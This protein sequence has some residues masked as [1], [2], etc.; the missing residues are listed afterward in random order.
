MTYTPRGVAIHDAIA[1]KTHVCAPGDV[2]PLHPETE[3]KFIRIAFTMNED[4]FKE[5]LCRIE[6]FCV[7]SLSHINRLCFQLSRT[8]SPGNAESNMR[9]LTVFPAR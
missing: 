2:L 4:L 8:V 6:K 1:L 9:F 7:D 5:A 3:Q